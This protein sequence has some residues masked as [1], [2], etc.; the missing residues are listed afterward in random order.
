MS[1]FCSSTAPSFG[2]VCASWLSL[3][4][5][6]NAATQNTRHVRFTSCTWVDSVPNRFLSAVE[7]QWGSLGTGLRSS[8]R[9]AYLVV[10]RGG[11]YFRNCTSLLYYKALL[12]LNTCPLTWLRFQAKNT[13][14]SFHFYL[15]FQSTCYKSQRSYHVP[16]IYM[17]GCMCQ[18]HELSLVSN[19]FRFAS[20]HVHKCII[21]K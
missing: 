12:K 20:N 13:F 17:T 3:S 2:S 14:D 10:F 1:H 4:T 21:N 9:G 8:E 15:D 18:S 11:Q 5:K 6:K 16:P 7:Q 19:H